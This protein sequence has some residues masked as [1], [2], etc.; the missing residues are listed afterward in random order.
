MIGGTLLVGPGSQEVG[1][2]TKVLKAAG[3]R[4]GPGPHGREVRRVGAAKRGGGLWL[5]RFR[6]GAWPHWDTGN[7]KGAL[8][9]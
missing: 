1:G 4:G 3:Q 5:A 8:L 6:P 7:L 2:V 9:G